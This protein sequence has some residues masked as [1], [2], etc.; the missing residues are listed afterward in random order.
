MSDNTAELAL[1][2][3]EQGVLRAAG[4]I[5]DGGHQPT[6]ERVTRSI[7]GQHIVAVSA[8]MTMPGDEPP[9]RADQHTYCRK[10][11]IALH[12]KRC[13]EAPIGADFF[14]KEAPFTLTPLGREWLLTN[15]D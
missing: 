1:S 9:T 4:A 12:T 11:L 14:P 15:R 3:E 6:L 2:K 5:I 13:I 10:H 7:F 8:A